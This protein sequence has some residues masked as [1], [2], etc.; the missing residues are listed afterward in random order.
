MLRMNNV[1]HED[2][3]GQFRGNAEMIGWKA[4]DGSNWFQHEA[5]GIQRAEWLEGQLRIQYKSNDESFQVLKLSGFSPG[6]FEP[7][8]RHFKEEWGVFIQKHRLTAAVE[9]AD[10]DKAMCIVEAYAD[11]V[12]E[13]EKGSVQK[14]AREADLMKKV[15][16]VRDGLDLAVRGDK[17]ALSR[18]FSANGC[19]RIGRLRLVVRTVNLEVYRKD[20]RW[21]DLKG[22][23][24]TIEAVLR[25]L[26]TFRTWRPP[27]DDQ[28]ASL[29]RR[30]LVWELRQRQRDDGAAEEDT[31]DD[32]V[33]SAGTPE[34]AADDV[35]ESHHVSKAKDM[36]A[37][38]L[39]DKPPIGVLASDGYPRG[40]GAE[41]TEPG[42]G[43]AGASPAGIPVP[44]QPTAS[45]P[46]RPANGHV[47][48]RIGANGDEYDD[49][50]VTDPNSVRAG[51]PDDARNAGTGTRANRL[52]YI[53]TDS[54][55]EGWV[56]KRSRYLKRWRRRWL[57]LLP[58]EIASFKSRSDE[59]PTESIAA[60]T[61]KS[62]RDADWEVGQTRCFCLAVARRNYYMVCD[63]DTQK[64]DWTREIRKAFDK[65]LS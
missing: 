34:G 31:S 33:E 19:E 3:E 37:H 48:A 18:V 12:D 64:R 28:H 22:M 55:M 54:I 13:A 29:A 21:R 58:S 10:F 43:T 5:S 57:V 52:Y 44:A 40:R 1:W 16:S 27:D 38:A 9:E 4:T 49:E 20:P 32:E 60:G 53:R 56:W 2:L 11:S 41:E 42:A 47:A 51:A 65:S 25:E 50:E 59:R 62:V 46:L 45:N 15:E 7:L 30:Y 23:A 61:L 17:Q 26:G 6:D 63:D 39:G 14:K 36:L 24:S 8:W 35:V